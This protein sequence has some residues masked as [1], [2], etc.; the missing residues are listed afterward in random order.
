MSFFHRTPQRLESETFDVLVIGAGIH[1]AGAAWDAASRGLK[2]ALIDKGDFGGQTSS[3]C[4]KIVHGGLRYIQHFD[5]PRIRQSVR[6]QRTLRLVAP[7]LVRPLPFLIPCYGSGMKSRP[8]LHAGL[9]LYDLL[10]ID[11]N[12]GIDS[13]EHILPS[14]KLLSREECLERAPLLAPDGLTGGV[15]YYDCQMVHCERLTLAVAQAAAQAGACALNY[16]EAIAATT[17]TDASGLPRVDSVVAR[18]L[19]SGQEFRIKAAQIILACGPWNAVVTRS[20]FPEAP[21]TT[22]RFS[23]GMQLVMPQTVSSCALAVES[24]YVDPEA[25]VA[26][27]GRAFFIQPWQ[28][29]SLLG[30]TDTLYTGDPDTFQVTKDEIKEFLHDIRQAYPSQVFTEENVHFAF[31][32]LRPLSDLWQEKATAAAS[33]EAKTAR[34]DTIVD[35]A[36]PAAQVRVSNVLTV[37]AIK[38]TTFRAVAEKV[39]NAVYGKLGRTVQSCVTSRSPVHGGAIRNYPEFLAEVAKKYP[40]VA[41]DTHLH[42]TSNYGTAVLQLFKMLDRE[43]HLSAKICKGRACIAAELVYAVR[44]EMAICLSD[45]VLRRTEL[46]TLGFPGRPALETAA[47]IVGRELQWDTARQQEEIERCIADFR[48]VSVMPIE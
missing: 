26:R 44:H 19:Q 38:Y 12:N 11:R 45:V 23:K 36:A 20:F 37:A 43:P 7:H 22:L 21:K 47:L 48:R 35:H 15:L 41:Q 30:T 17:T 29:Y 24:H 25:K 32:G 10:S 4:F 1:G 33:G 2:T 40:A 39:I 14:H 18:D 5:L 42:L 28:G 27:G 9:T 6:E 8:V 16:V 3:G 13:A 46:G 34:D 31:G